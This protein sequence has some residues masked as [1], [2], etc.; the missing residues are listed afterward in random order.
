MCNKLTLL[1]LTYVIVFISVV[2]CDSTERKDF[3]SQDLSVGRTFGHNALKRLSFIFLPVMFTLG[4]ISTLLM[5]LAVISVKNLAIGVMLLIVAVS[6][7]VSRLFLT[8]ASPSPL[9]HLHPRAE[10]LPAP[11][12]PAPW[13]AP[14]PLLSP[15]A[16]SDNDAPISD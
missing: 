11:A 15:W 7:A 12:V 3:F 5:A 6:Q 4:V 1:S 10:L 14:G 2:Q 8:A 13:P 9:V 16:R